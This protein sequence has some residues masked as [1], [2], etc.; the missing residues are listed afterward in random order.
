MSHADD[1]SLSQLVGE[2]LKR[3]DSTQL[4]VQGL[5]EA[6]QDEVNLQEAEDARAVSSLAEDDASSSSSQEDSQSSDPSQPVRTG[7]WWAHLLK[8]HTR[9]LTSGT[10]AMFTPPAHHRTVL[11]AC[12]GCFAEAEVL[13]VHWQHYGTEDVAVSPELSVT[14]IT[15]ALTPIAVVFTVL[16]VACIVYKSI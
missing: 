16:L 1:D 12:T 3:R 8:A 6:S 14:P 15:V 13:K 7:C 10:Q 5:L 9:E 2:L 4:E 11:S